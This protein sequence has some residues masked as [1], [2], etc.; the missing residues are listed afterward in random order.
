MLKQFLQSAIRPTR[1]C[2]IGYPSS[3]G[4]RTVKSIWSLGH[5][6]FPILPSRARLLTHW[7][8]ETRVGALVVDPNDSVAD[9]V[10]TASR[11]MGVPVMDRVGELDVASTGTLIVEARASDW[12]VPVTVEISGDRLNE[13]I[14]VNSTLFQT[15][16]KLMPFSFN[17]VLD[18]CSC[19][20]RVVFPGTRATPS[21]PTHLVV[22]PSTMDELVR[23]VEVEKTVALTNLD[24]VVIDWPFS[25]DLIVEKNALVERV[26][27]VFT[28]K[29]LVFRYTAPQVGPVT[30]LVPADHSVDTVTPM[31]GKFKLRVDEKFLQVVSTVPVEYIGRSSGDSSTIQIPLDLSPEESR[32]RGRKRREMRAEWRVK[33]VPIAVYHKKRGFK[34]QI[35]YTTKHKGWTLYKSRY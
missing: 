32:V 1:V 10:M 20:G 33:K 34:G 9:E 17:W 15:A 27:E 11:C 35:Y 23:L 5:S 19:D 29:N 18:A 6:V 22:D 16:G 8:A 26:G 2:L 7:I 13:Q 28:P 3:A 30:G 4:F 12:I 25:D 24:T 21:V 31:S 14:M